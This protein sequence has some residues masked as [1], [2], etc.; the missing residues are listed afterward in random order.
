MKGAIFALFW[1]S[2]NYFFIYITYVCRL[3]TYN[4]YFTIYSIF[5]DKE[6]SSL[7]RFGLG[8]GAQGHT[9]LNIN[10][11]SIGSKRLMEEPPTVDEDSE[12]E[13]AR[14]AWKKFFQPRVSC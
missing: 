1:L 3:H 8:L 11:L 13:A 7:R 2:K 10:S 9:L 5:S 12:A 14:L 4:I 6:W